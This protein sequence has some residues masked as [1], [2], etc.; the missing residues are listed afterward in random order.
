MKFTVK[1]FHRESIFNVSTVS[2]KG[3]MWEHFPFVEAFSVSTV[4]EADAGGGIVSTVA[5][6]GYSGNIS[7]LRFT[8]ETF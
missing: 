5:R 2:L 8:V 4:G 1:T 6:W 7:K 3:L